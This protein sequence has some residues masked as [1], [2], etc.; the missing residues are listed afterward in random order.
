MRDRPEDNRVPVGV[1]KDGSRWVANY[2][3]HE[4]QGV[5]VDGYGVGH[6]LPAP[7]DKNR[8]QDADDYHHEG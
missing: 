2:Q 4:N 8:H 1:F 7:R 3:P 6:C 5:E